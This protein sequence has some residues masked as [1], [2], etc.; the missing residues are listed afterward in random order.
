[1]ENTPLTSTVGRHNVNGVAQI[2]NPTMPKTTLSHRW[3]QIKFVLRLVA[4]TCAL[5]AF[6]VSFVWLAAPTTGFLGD[7]MP[8]LWFIAHVSISIIAQQD[9]LSLS[10]LPALSSAR[11]NM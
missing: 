1:M 4:L 2:S 11:G 3:I 9:S 7:I 10:L 8:P 5:V 6:V